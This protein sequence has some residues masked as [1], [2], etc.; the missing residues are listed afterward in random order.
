MEQMFPQGSPY[1]LLWGVIT[2]AILWGVAWV[3]GR[4][5]RIVYWTW[6][7]HFKF[8]SSFKKFMEEEFPDPDQRD[9]EE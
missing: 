7:W 3:T 2:A 5:A 8:A 6:W 1:F 4:V 9:R